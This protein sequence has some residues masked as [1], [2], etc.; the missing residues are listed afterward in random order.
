MKVSKRYPTLVLMMAIFCLP[1][2]SVFVCR[3]CRFLF[4]VLVSQYFAI[5]VSRYWVRFSYLYRVLP[6][7]RLQGLL[8]QSMITNYRLRDSLFNAIMVV[9]G[10]GV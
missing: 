3:S 7:N 10:V 9:D 8:L 5:L 2:L 6:S 4:A 1:F